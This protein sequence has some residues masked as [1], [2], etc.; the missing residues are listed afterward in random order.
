[1][2]S[3]KAVDVR[4]VAVAVAVTVAALAYLD[5]H[6]SPA[7]PVASTADRGAAVQAD[8]ART[9]LAAHLEA[10]LGDDFGGVWYEPSSGRFHVGVT[11]AASRRNAEAVAAQAGLAEDVVETPVTSTWAQLIAAQRR[12][13][14]RLADLFERA[15]AKTAIVTDRNALE[16]E[17]GS[18][19]PPRRRAGLEREARGD[20]VEV[21]VVVAPQPQIVFR[22]AN[23]RC[24]K[25]AQFKAWCDKTI[26]SG[27]SI[28]N[29]TENNA[30]GDCTAGPAALKVERKDKVTLTETFILTA[31]HCIENAG[32]VGKKWHAFDK[33]GNRSEIGPAVAAFPE[34]TDVG[35]IEVKIP[36]WGLKSVVPVEAKQAWWSGVEETDP[37]TPTTQEDPAKDQLVCMSGQR[38][39]SV[40]GKVTNATV[41][42]AFEIKKNVFKTYNKLAEVK[43]DTGVKAG[44]GDSGA[45]WFDKKDK[46][47][48]LGVMSSV[49]KEGM[50]EESTVAAFQWLKTSFAELKSKKSLDL[51][52]LTNKNEIR[53]D[54]LKGAQ[55]PVTLHGGVAGG[56]E[57]IVTEG[58]SVE[59]GKTSH[60]G[61][62]SEAAPAWTDT[63]KYEECSAFGFTGATVDMEGCAYEYDSIEDVS[64]DNFKAGFNVTCPAGKSIKVTGGSCKMEIPAQTGLT[65]VDLIDDTSASPKRDITLRPTVMSLAYTVTQDG[66]LCPFNGTGG[67]TC[68]EYNSTENLTITGQSPSE[69]ATKIDIEVVGA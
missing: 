24:A 36:G 12:W 38:S 11:S 40:C 27:V 56:V 4:A 14:R 63:P 46:T 67:K 57:R 42:L 49:Q 1:M 7:Q 33:K 62:I 17:V 28:D 55:Y 10:A 50:S 19:V 48:V 6:R 51:E 64:A 20:P 45:P 61:L 22:G 13:D 47:K 32:G 37:L 26:V 41:T 52:L 68:G 15:E 3:S 2:K 21:S 16:I 31:G 18:R 23:F 69:P 25:F 53:H 29:E 65:T 54:S 44:D 34:E 30:Q 5:A 59:C 66:F 43:M 58:G 8:V 9:G 39:G 60:H 35:A